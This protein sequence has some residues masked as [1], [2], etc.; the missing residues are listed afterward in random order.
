MIWDV[1]S[2]DQWCVE[3]GK[4][5]AKNVFEPLRAGLDGK[6]INI[7]SFFRSN[8]LNDVIH[9]AINSQHLANN[10]AAMDIDNDFFVYDGCSSNVEIFNFIYKHLDFDQ[11]IWEFGDDSCPSWVH[12]SFNGTKNRK[13]VL[14]AYKVGGTTKYKPYV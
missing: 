8:D 4:E 3:L 10:G 6:P 13:Q 7:S 2:Y 5:L 12:V 11:L 14:K 9:G 1:Y